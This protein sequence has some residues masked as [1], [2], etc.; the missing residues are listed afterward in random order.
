MPPTHL[1]RSKAQGERSGV[2][3]LPCTTGRRSR[4]AQAGGEQRTAPKVGRRQHDRRTTVR[5]EEFVV[6]AAELTRHAGLVWGNQWHHLATGTEARSEQGRTDRPRLSRPWNSTGVACRPC[7]VGIRCRSSGRGLTPDRLPAGPNERDGI[8]LQ[9]FRSEP[10]AFRALVPRRTHVQGSQLGLDRPQ[11]PVCS[12][13]GNGD[14]CARGFHPGKG[15]P[16]RSHP[17]V[18]VGRGA[19]VTGRLL[20]RQAGL[21]PP[22]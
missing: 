10:V 9:P 22:G 5:P 11:S 20:D 1:A 4:P 18:Y 13:L 6:S 12:Q 21:D 8:E 17:R 16:C 7:V 19:P 2:H 15:A 3:D 14:R